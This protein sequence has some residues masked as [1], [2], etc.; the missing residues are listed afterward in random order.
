M[1]EQ[2]AM[3]VS[4]SINDA[5][6]QSILLINGVNF[7]ELPE[8]PARTREPL[9]RS[10]TSINMNGQIKRGSFPLLRN[11][12]LIPVSVQLNQLSKFAKLQVGK[13]IVTSKQRQG[14]K[15]PLFPQSI[16]VSGYDPLKKV[17]ADYQPPPK[18]QFSIKVNG[19]SYYNLVK[20]DIDFDPS[21]VEVFGCTSV[22]LNDDYQNAI[23]GTMPWILDEIDEK[24]N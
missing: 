17:E 7:S 11:G 24:I 19:D 9:A 3:T 23:K 12:Q 13:Q 16:A 10:K 21:K 8:A 6:K 14:S 1:H 5:Q 20:E 4:I 15:N 18:N 2:R 22:I